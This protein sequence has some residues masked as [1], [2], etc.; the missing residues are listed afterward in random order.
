[1]EPLLA[2][3]TNRL[4]ASSS[5]TFLRNHGLDL[6]TPPFSHDRRLT[7][8]STTDRRGPLQRVACPMETRTAV[9]AF[10]GPCVCENTQRR[11]LHPA[12]Q[13]P[14]HRLSLLT[15]A[16]HRP[17]RP[18]SVASSQATWRTLRSCYVAVPG[19]SSVQ[20]PVVI[21]PDF[22]RWFRIPPTALTSRTVPRF[23]VFPSLRFP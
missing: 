18:R 7:A 14:T 15:T 16:T 13:M 9:D 23:V 22:A 21:R 4:D 3:L 10:V 12:N 17:L 8:W 5:T 1:M 6:R 20:P 19:I 11:S 2:H